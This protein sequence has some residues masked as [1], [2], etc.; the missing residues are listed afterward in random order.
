MPGRATARSS[1]R[2][3]DV[4]APRAAWIAIHLAMPPTALGAR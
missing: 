1:S 3:R 4:A 2:A